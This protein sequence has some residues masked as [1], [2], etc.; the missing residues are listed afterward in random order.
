MR[1]LVGAF[2]ENAELIRE[3]F[4]TAIVCLRDGNYIKRHKIRD[5]VDFDMDKKEYRIKP[6]S[7]IGHNLSEVPK[8][9][10][11]SVFKKAWG[12]LVRPIG[13][14]ESTKE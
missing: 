8:N 3:N 2:T 11:S 14:R 5:F 9:R 13:Q 4:H 6:I 10:W 7:D 12:T 1:V